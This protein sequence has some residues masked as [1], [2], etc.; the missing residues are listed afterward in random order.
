MKML[1]ALFVLTLIAVLSACQR[2]APADKLEFALQLAGKNRGELEKVIAHYEAEGDSLKLKAAIFLIENLPYGHSYA[3]ELVDQYDG[4]FKELD[5][6][7]SKDAVAALFK[8]YEEKFGKLEIAKLTQENDP[9]VITAD[10]LIQN[11]DQAFQAWRNNPWSK[12][13]SF[14]LFCQGILPYRALNEPL[15][16]WRPLFTKEY[17]WLKDSL[18]NSSDILRVFGIIHK[19]I[20]GEYDSS[21]EWEYPFIPTYTNT[22][23]AKVGPCEVVTSVLVSTMRA[24]GLPAFREFIPRFANRA[25][26]HA[27]PALVDDDGV[28]YWCY[29]TEDTIAATGLA[30]PSSLRRLEPGALDHLPY[31]MHLDTVRTIPKIY[32]TVFAPNADKLKMMEGVREREK[33]D[34]LCTPKLMDVTH[35]YVKNSQDVTL[36]LENIPSGNKLVYLGIFDKMEWFP[37]AVTKV[38]GKKAT[39][40]NMGPNIVYV[41]MAIRNDRKTIIGNPFYLENGNKIEITP[42]VN[43]KTSVTLFRKTNF[44]GN[45]INYANRMLNGHF[46]GAN[47]PDF[48]DAEVL[49]TIEQTPI[50]MNEAA[51]QSK[52]TFRYVRFVASA[53]SEERCEVAELEFYTTENGQE[54]KLDGTIIGSPAR[55]VRVQAHAMDGNWDSFFQS[56]DKGD[57]WIGLDI[58][59]A[60]RITKIRYC[61]RNDT[62]MIKPGD[63]YVL[64][65]WNQDDWISLGIQKATEMKITFDDVPENALLWLRNVSGGSEENVFV[66][67]NGQQVFF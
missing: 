10:L 2:A 18:Q 12:N 11:I 19:N 39:F 13:I 54:R 15:E 50:Y 44:F 34:W 21:L 9:E 55:D 40:K 45:I 48:S 8:T 24:N 59:T 56:E 47:Q 26:G 1:Q 42:D 14:D 64:F 33:I 60:K 65:Y 4:I 32:R 16:N 7:M 29:G 27:F 58:G 49:Y 57:G 23:T 31:P 52:K 51:I 20:N 17:A 3:G 46:E 61:P 63:S 37:V 41:P 25:Y 67:Q 30:V 5:P 35:H 43:K 53:A 36:T 6:K 62:N 28:T 38:E 66:M 22:T